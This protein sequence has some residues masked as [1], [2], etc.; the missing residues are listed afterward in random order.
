MKYLLTG[1]FFLLSLFGQAQ[2]ARSSALYQLLQQ[3]D[4]LVFDVGFNACHLLPYDSIISDD[5]EFYHDKG[6]IEMGKATF[7][8]SVKNN[9][10]GGG[11][12]MKRSLVD[13]TLQVFPLFHKKILYG[14]I[15]QGQHDFYVLENQVWRKSG[16]ALFI[17]LW[18]LEDGIWKLKRVLSYD[19]K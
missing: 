13:S 1:C 4:H 6:G 12:K 15:Q 10:C 19:H 16:S 17:H 7:I 18:L 2:E 9:I 5:V 8:A 3:R 14:A 11:Y